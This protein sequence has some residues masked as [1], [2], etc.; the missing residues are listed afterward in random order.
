ME[1]RRDRPN[2]RSVM[3]IYGRDQ[4]ARDSLF[5]FL[6]ALKLDPLEWDELVKKTG[7]GSPY[8]GK[9]IKTGFDQAQAAVVLFTPDDEARLRNELC[10]KDDGLE[11]T[12][13]SGQA[14][15]NVLI[16]AGM[17]LALYPDRTILLQLGQVRSAS[18]LSGRHIIKLEDNAK[19]RNKLVKSLETAG[20]SICTTG[21]DWLKAGDF[22]E[23]TSSLPSRKPL[24]SKGS[25]C[26]DF[27]YFVVIR[28]AKIIHHEFHELYN[29]GWQDIGIAAR[30]LFRKASEGNK[31]L[32]IETCEDR[33]EHSK[34]ARSNVKEHVINDLQKHI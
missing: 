17:A 33:W 32:L 31:P 23:I 16:E 7:E 14:R 1:M 9:V 26:V 10:S 8:T 27:S 25:V 4:R 18:D 3:V 20:C 2:N 34:D 13:L 19:S 21:E 24:A 29:Q 12:Q 6:R 22:K 30:S 11:E 15:Q 28:F 5:T